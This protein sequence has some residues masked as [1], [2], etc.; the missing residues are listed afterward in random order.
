ME[1]LF[2]F[3][4]LLL[5]AALSFIVY[6]FSEK[7]KEFLIRHEKYF[8][9]VKKKIACVLSVKKCRDYVLYSE[10]RL[11]PFPQADY[12]PR[13]FFRI[14]LD[15]GD[16]IN[17]SDTAVPSELRTGSYLAYRRY[18]LLLG[19]IGVDNA[20]DFN[21]VPVSVVAVGVFVK[22]N[23]VFIARR[24]EKQSYP[25]LWEFPGGKIEA[26]ETAVQAVIRELREELE[27]EVVVIGELM[28]TTL[29]TPNKIFTLHA[30]LITAP[31]E[32]I[33]PLKVH[34]Q[35]CWAEIK[36]LKNYNFCAADVAIVDWIQ[37]LYRCP[38]LTF[39][40]CCQQ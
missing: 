38:Y 27:I 32:N 28:K 33:P 35:T 14:L 22:N 23:R 7:E 31:V 11:I 1:T 16:K 18:P 2:I 6:Y 5:F 19:G 25:G 37:R 39:E 3:L 26:G 21:V 20:F 30:Y 24:G 40:G 29:V 8:P 36:D 9:S 4:V 34:S 12:F 15:N 17:I 13:F 10:N